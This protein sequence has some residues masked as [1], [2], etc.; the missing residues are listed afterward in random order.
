MGPISVGVW[1]TDTRHGTYDVSVIVEGR[2]F[3]KKQVGLDE[4]LAIKIG[5]APPMELVVNRVGRNDVS[6]YLSTP[7]EFMAR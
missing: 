6:G 3:D 2:R 7:N 5:T 1:R 4:A